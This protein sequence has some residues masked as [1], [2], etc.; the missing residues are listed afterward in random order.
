MVHIDDYSSG[1]IEVE[2]EKYTGDIII[3]PDHIDSNWKRKEGHS[4]YKEDIKKI[5]ENP[6][7]ILVIGKGTQGRLRLLPETRRALQ[8]KE[9]QIEDKK[10]G[11][12]CKVFN[13]LV[14]EGKDVVAALHLTC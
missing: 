13:N 5:L 9:I 6:P 4:L 3:Y 7:N 12:A 11:R 2:G 10:T 14:E 1:E 8:N